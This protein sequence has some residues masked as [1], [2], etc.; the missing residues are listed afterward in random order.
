[1]TAD[2]L[3]M[4]ARQP[5]DLATRVQLLKNY[6]MVHSGIGLDVIDELLARCAQGAQAQAAADRGITQV[7]AIRNAEIAMLRAALEA[8]REYVQHKDGCPCARQPVWS[9]S[10][11][12]YQGCISNPGADCSCGL[13]S[14]LR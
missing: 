10:K 11:H 2:A 3:L 5:D 4:E 12:E 14:K 9:G 13:K 6:L 7:N 8:L 1:M